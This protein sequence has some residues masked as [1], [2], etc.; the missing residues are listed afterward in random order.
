MAPEFISSNVVTVDPQEPASEGKYVAV[1]FAD[2][3][4]LIRE[5]VK[6]TPSKIRLRQLNPEG[7]STHPIEDIV[8]IHR[9]T[10]SARR[11]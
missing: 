9:I 7:E 11:V 6:R 1:W 10:M 8:A 2:G 3:K 4:C 5:L